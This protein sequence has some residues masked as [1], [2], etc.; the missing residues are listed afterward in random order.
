M[1]VAAEQLQRAVELVRT[2][3]DTPRRNTAV[4]HLRD[5]VDA[6]KREERPRKEERIMSDTERLVWAAVF[7]AHWT[8]QTERIRK[9]G[10]EVSD[11]ELADAAAG[12][13]HRALEALHQVLDIQ[14]LEAV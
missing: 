4:A 3:I 2:Y 12:Q 7:A 9:Y 13:A 6:V 10:G 1:S 8:A 11:R 14:A 5:V